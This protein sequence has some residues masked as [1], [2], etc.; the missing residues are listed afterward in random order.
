MAY[1]IV[2]KKFTATLE[3]TARSS[4]EN[5]YENGCVCFYVLGSVVMY[6]IMH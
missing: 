2:K 5:E 1:L 3:Q 6:V 4:K